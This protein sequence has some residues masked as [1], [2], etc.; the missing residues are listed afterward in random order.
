MANWINDSEAELRHIALK[1]EVQNQGIGRQLVT[2][3]ISII[4][5]QGCLRIHTIARNTSA[6][7]FRNLGFKTAPGIPPEHSD[8][9]KHGITFEL[10]ER[11]VEQAN[12]A[13]GK[14]RRR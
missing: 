4:S 14:T 13:D 5:C 12:P 7:F 11:N 3:L 6:G 1:P 2:S 9:K 8:F 10:M